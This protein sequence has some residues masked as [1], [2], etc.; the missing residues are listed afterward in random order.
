MVSRLSPLCA[1]AHWEPV[2]AP[3]LASISKHPI[4]PNG[5]RVLGKSQYRYK[6]RGA[7]LPIFLVRNGTPKRANNSVR[8]NTSTRLI[9]TTIHSPHPEHSNNHCHIYIQKLNR[10][11]AYFL[12]RAGF[13]R[14]HN[15]AHT[16][17][18]H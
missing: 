18:L 1:S 5:V 8:K 3:T 2:I 6:P 4:L 12:E 13:Y 15:I 10:Q 14:A 9:D 17:W 7:V 16:P 11:Y